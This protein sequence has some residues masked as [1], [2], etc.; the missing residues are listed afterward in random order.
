MRAGARVSK[1]KRKEKKRKKE[2]FAAQRSRSARSS[3][4][5]VT[6]EV[7]E[8][9]AGR[10]GSSIFSRKVLQQP[11]WPRL[12]WPV[13]FFH[14]D[15]QN[16]TR[17]DEGHH[18]F[19]RQIAVTFPRKFAVIFLPFILLLFLSQF[20]FPLFRVTS[21]TVYIYTCMYVCVRVHAFPSRSV[22]AWWGRSEFYL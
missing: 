4:F 1:K 2:Y 5:H 13:S 8:G 12:A 11:S 9:V 7:W 10:K 3:T 6:N 18:T 21:S 20:L 17:R 22:V 14:P 16:E 19:R 15:G